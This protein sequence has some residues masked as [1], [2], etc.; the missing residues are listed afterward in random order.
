MPVDVRS[1][2]ADFLGFSGHKMLGPTGTGGFYGRK[3][4]LEELP[5]FFT[6]G[7]MIREVRWEDATWNDL[8]WKFEAGT[9]NIAGGIG[10]GAAIDYLQ[11]VGLENI[12]RHE[13]ALTKYAM[14][15]LSAMSG[16]EL[17]GPKRR[18]GIIAFNIKGAH[19]HDVAAIM[20]QEGICIRGGHHCTMP[21]HHHLG[22]PAS[23]RASFALYNTEEEI[24]RLAAAIDRVK[25]VFKV[26]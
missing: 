10:L 1:L 20:D 24:D 11:A 14:E 22:I 6:G 8:P 16:V 5:P 2:G 18:A 4:L 21:L 25:K 26:N 23:A 17:Y 15:K 9:P 3:D 13:Q 7:D 19:A 12:E